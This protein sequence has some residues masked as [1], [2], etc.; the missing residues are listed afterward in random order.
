MDEWSA[1]AADL[2]VVATG[3]HELQAEGK[4]PYAL[5]DAAGHGPMHG[6]R[7]NE[8]LA[9]FE[10][11]Y[12]IHNKLPRDL[13]EQGKAGDQAR[14]CRLG[15]AALRLFVH[16]FG[17]HDLDW[18]EVE[19]RVREP[20]EIVNAEP[21]DVVFTSDWPILTIA[22]FGRGFA[23]EAAGPEAT[24]A[25]ARACGGKKQ[26]LVAAVTEF[27]ACH[28]GCDSALPALQQA[29]AALPPQ[30]CPALRAAAALSLGGRAPVAAVR[31]A[32]QRFGAAG[33]Q[34]A[35]RHPMP[36][37]D[38]LA[39][40]QKRPHIERRRLAVVYLRDPERL[41]PWYLVGHP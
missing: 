27:L 9:L 4:S 15:Y 2:R 19:E 25:L 40:L 28:H 39:T 8:I 29:A 10:K 12:G 7:T 32:A 18:A 22:R 11:L 26:P 6:Y 20:W 14:S 35:M 31:E 33:L 37:L 1:I 13:E 17:T 23:I 36:L 38:L 3:L 24:K 41:P 30:A 21:W 16:Y 5:A 34:A